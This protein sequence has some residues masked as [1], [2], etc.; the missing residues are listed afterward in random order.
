LVAGDSVA[1]RLQSLT[2]FAPAQSWFSVHSQTRRRATRSWHQAHSQ[3]RAGRGLSAQNV[4]AACDS[5][6]C[7]A[8]MKS[9]FSITAFHTKSVE[10]FS[11]SRK[12]YFRC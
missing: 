3:P 4:R 7:P 2:K 5:T 6:L 10:R 8:R 12:R 11:P 9:G 1:A